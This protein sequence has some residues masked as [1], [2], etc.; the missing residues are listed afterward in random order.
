MDDDSRDEEQPEPR[1][2]VTTSIDEPDELPEDRP[3]RALDRLAEPAVLVLL[4]VTVLW[5]IVFFVLAALRHDRHGTFGFDLGIFDQAVWLTSRFRDPFITVRGLDSWGHH[6]NAIFFLLAPFYWVGAGAKFLLAVQVLSQASGAIAVYLI[7][8]ERLVSRWF[9]VAMALVLLLNPTYQWLVWEFFHP[10]ALAI[11]PL[12]FAYWA[13]STRRWGWFWFSAVL[14]I[15]CKEDVALTILMLG[16]VVAFRMGARRRGL[17]IAAFGA[18]WFLLTTRVLLP[19]FNDAER[20]FYND[21]FASELG[22]SLGDV[23][24]NTARNPS[25]TIEFL[26]NDEH[27]TYY[28]RMAAP[29]ALLPLASPSTLAIALPMIVVNMLTGFPYTRDF[30][31]HYSSLVVVGGIVATIEA[32]AWWSRGND[33]RRGALVGFVLATA[34][35]TSVMWGPSPIGV[36]YRSG[37]WPL[38]ADTRLEA[39]QTALDLVPSGAATSASYNFVPHLTHRARIYEFPVPWCNINW[40]VSG[41]DLHEPAAV[42]WL[43]VDLN[44]IGEEHRARLEE[45]LID[46]FTERFRRD[47]VVVAERTAEADPPWGPADDAGACREREG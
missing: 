45:L 29:F 40:G 31:F 2:A 47:N 43:A 10:E 25:Q 30:R 37:I 28:W 7:A 32:I 8:K 16:L 34:L 41:E 4:G 42:E 38:G 46:E 11:G 12:L 1:D 3:L 39:K 22:T 19:M 36:D 18:A 24:K 21:F 44:V 20:A 6:N 23:I 15:S 5:A 14:A 33:R 13:A 26:T 27:R 9:A 17:V 35:A